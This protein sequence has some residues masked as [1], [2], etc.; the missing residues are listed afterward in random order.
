MS[1]HFY[2]NIS[3]YQMDSELPKGWTVHR[4]DK[5][6]NQRI[7]FQRGDDTTW[8]MPE[9]I[10]YDLSSNQ[11]Q[12]LYFLCEKGKSPMPETFKRFLSE[13]GTALAEVN[14]NI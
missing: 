6:Y 9:E 5:S 11:I 3:I 10:L 14:K 8:D 13:K 1:P 4:S 2:I 12:F 7:F